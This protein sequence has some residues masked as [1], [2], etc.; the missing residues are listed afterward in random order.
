MSVVGGPMKMTDDA[1]VPADLAALPGLAVYV[2][3]SVTDCASLSAKAQH[4]LGV[5]GPISTDSFF[6]RVHAEDR[7]RF[8]AETTA[9]LEAGGNQSREFRWIR[10]DGQVLHLLAHTTLSRS[11]ADGQDQIT[12]VF[13]DMTA[14]RTRDNAA[15][16]L[17]K[18][19][20]GFYNYDVSSQTTNWSPELRRLFSV[21]QNSILIGDEIF[22]CVH[23]Q[24][25]A[26][27]D[28]GMQAALRTIGPF[29][30]TFR[31]DTPDGLTRWVQDRG[32]THAPIDPVTG[33]ASRVTGTLTD[34][35]HQIEDDAARKLA[36]DTFWRLIDTAPFGVY[37]VDADLRIVRVSKG[38]QAAFAGI[39]NLLG[40]GLCDV[41]HIL[42]PAAFAAEV[43]ARFQ[44]TLDTGEPYRAPAF[45]R[46]RA[47]RKVL[48]AYDWGIER[49]ELEDGRF[50]VVCHFYD[51]SERVRHEKMQE[52]QQRRLNIAYNAADMGA[53]EVDYATGNVTWTAQL[54]RIFGVNDQ[55]GD[56]KDIWARSVHPEDADLVRG[57]VE[58][59]MQDGASFDMDYRIILESGEIRYLAT[60]GEVSCDVHGTPQMMI[61]VNHDITDRKLTEMAL[62]VSEE[63]MRMVMDHTLAFVGV[64]GMD[65]TLQKVNEIALE[66]GGLKRSDVVGKPFWETF[67]WTHDDAVSAQLK[68]AVMAGLDGQSSR[69]DVAVRGVDDR[70]ITVDFLLA[71][72]FGDAGDLRMLV[73]S[74]FDISERE[75]ARRRVQALMGEVNHRTKNILTLVQIL[76]RQSARGGAKDFVQR[77]EKR[78]SALAAAQDLLVKSTDD[79]V[80]LKELAQSQLAH[81]DDGCDTRIHLSG[82]P[83]E[84]APQAAQGIGMALH[85]LATNAGKY[86]AMSSDHGRIDVIWQIDTAPSEA[87]FVM[88]WQEH[89]GPPVI[90][91][92]GRGF[93]STV[94]DQM[95]RSIL[96]GTV[97]LEYAPDGL[98]WRLSC[99]VS[100]LTR[101]Q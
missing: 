60:K 24:D 17:H 79:R 20:F 92:D 70:L 94:I 54:Y 1:N 9:F 50:G 87:E 76:A 5:P 71:P 40:R 33:L 52:E 55:S 12:G 97:Q 43:V 91:P 77:F 35:T 101:R 62:R 41:M 22:D 44:H 73:V 42:W 26:D 63:R 82:P 84:L 99:P 16:P 48:E 68:D 37:A 56:P 80:D 36:N 10:P 30:M 19:Q 15:G 25:R 2:W 28:E 81:F 100:A 61:G 46:D 53:W 23:P 95:T 69:Y 39:E 98:R 51:L 75:E 57:I 14:L 45:V 4:L 6:D 59:A 90:P 89:D 83:I 27:F 74:G 47:D 3:S 29:E 66:F 38:G 85:E 11:D 18:G 49:M 65:G 21:P 31:I 86:G 72:V 67:W 64:L 93:G 96:G 8:E 34:I 7:I 13:I 78:V 32:E 58:K 88:Q